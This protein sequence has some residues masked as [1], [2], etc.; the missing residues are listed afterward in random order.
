MLGRVWTKIRPAIF[1]DY[2]RGSW[3]Y[4]IIVV[5]I[6]A[7]IFLS[8]RTMFNDRP[9]EPLIRE[10]ETAP[11]GVVVYWIDPGAQDRANPEAAG[12]RLRELLRRQTGHGLTVLKAEPARDQAGNIQGFLVYAERN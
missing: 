7:F 2:G 8:P 4:D 6:L 10:V 12:P 9:S 11:E 1:F 3:Q 5:L